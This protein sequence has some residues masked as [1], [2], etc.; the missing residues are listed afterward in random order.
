M[1][2]K[3]S[4]VVFAVMMI[5]SSLTEAAASRSK[6]CTYSG[7]A[8]G[9]PIPQITSISAKKPEAFEENVL[10]NVLGI[11]E[12]AGEITEKALEL[13]HASPQLALTFGAIAIALGIAQSEPSPQDILDRAHESIQFLANDVNE[14]LNQLQDYADVKDLQLQREVMTRNYKELF[15]QWQECLT[16]QT[17]TEADKCQERVEGAV[18]S[19]RYQFQPLQSIYEEKDCDDK[20]LYDPNFQYRYLATWQWM[21]RNKGS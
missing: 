1:S 15:D 10:K 8:P 16:Y 19:A 13:S 20:P 21:N 3:W 4:M 17:K 6:Q 11:G 2:I 18:E 7:Y 12:T 14:R 9:G 5:Q